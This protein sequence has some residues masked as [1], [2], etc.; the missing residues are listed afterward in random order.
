MFV[1]NGLE[2]ICDEHPDLVRN[3]VR[4]GGDVI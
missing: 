4:W 1:G 2:E 3:Y